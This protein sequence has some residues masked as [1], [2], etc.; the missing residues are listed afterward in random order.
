L[1]HPIKVTFAAFSD[2]EALA[3]A[4]LGQTDAV[5]IRSTGLTK[6]QISYRLKKAKNLEHLA[7]GYR[8]RWRNGESD[9]CQKIKK[10]LLSVIR[11]DIQKTMPVQ[12]AKPEVKTVKVHPKLQ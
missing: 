9:I 3:L 12:I 1:K 5:I 4:M 7:H 11:A 8:V 10:D 6:G 2:A